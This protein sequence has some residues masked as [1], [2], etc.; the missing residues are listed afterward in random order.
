MEPR[1]DAGI[2]NLVG[3][4]SQVGPTVS[5][6]R[7]GRAGD[8]DPGNIDGCKHRLRDT[9]EGTALFAMGARIL[10]V[11]RRGFDRLPG[12]VALGPRV[13][14]NVAAAYNGDRPPEVM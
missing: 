3:I 9:G 8:R 7:S 12:S 5:D 13:V 4:V 10:G 1:P 2:G 11:H 6:A 14:V